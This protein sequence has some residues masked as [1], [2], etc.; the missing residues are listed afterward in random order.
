MGEKMWKLPAGLGNGVCLF[1]LG[2]ILQLS[3][4]PF[5]WPWLASPVNGI[6]LL[7]LL[8]VIGLFY[9]LRE[10]VWDC[11][12]MM[13]GEAACS[14]LIWTLCL[15]L[16]MGLVPQVPEGG[17]SRLSQMLTF[18]PFVLLWSWTMLVLGLN[19]LRLLTHFQWADLPLIL[20][21]LGFFAA[22]VAAALG[23]AGRQELEMT[24]AQGRSEWRALNEN[25]EE[26]LPGF[27]V[28]LHTFTIDFHENHMPKRYASDITVTT[29]DGKTVRGTVEVNKPLRAD[30]WNIYQYAYDDTDDS[31]NPS[32]IFLLVK[33]PW[34][35]GVYAGIYLMLAGALGLVFARTGR[36]SKKSL[37]VSVVLMLLAAVFVYLFTPLIRVKMLMP[38]LQSPWFAPHVIVYMFAYA[39]MTAAT[40]MALY[41]L[42]FRRNK[43]VEKEMNV[44]DNLVYAGFAFLT[45]GMLFGALWAKEAWGHYW[46]WDPKETWAAITWL[47]Y[48]LYIHFR[49]IRPQDG[50]T[51][52]RILLVAFV[53]L[54]TCWWGVNYLPSARGLSDHTYN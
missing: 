34:L 23:S 42:V 9:F 27:T 53:C 5:Q 51:A 26:V 31:G 52:C 17:I 21:H 15:M 38:A 4:G 40:L 1:V 6:V 7:L 48:L 54:I 36:R 45:F 37:L 12:W 3:V 18:W 16:V 19:T 32:S 13:T 29:K 10:K 20:V 33:D 14:S 43:S 25:S 28:E 44:T 49:L 39:L 11:G 46:G 50:K 24:V 35:P 2:M 22:V 41:V 30:G 47:C 8:C